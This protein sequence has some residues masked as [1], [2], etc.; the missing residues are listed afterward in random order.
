[1]MN[2]RTSGPV[3]VHLIW[4]ALLV[5]ELYND[6]CPGA[7]PVRTPRSTGGRIYKEDIKTMGLMISARIFLLFSPLLVYWS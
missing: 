4:T 5:G 6:P 1:M 2:Q 7:W 3:N